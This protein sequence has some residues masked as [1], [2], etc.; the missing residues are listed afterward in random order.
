MEYT[1]FSQEETEGIGEKIAKKI[2][3][4]RIENQARVIS[5]EGELGSG[6]TTFLK[7]FARGFGIEE[8]IKSPSFVIMKKYRLPVT[9]Y[10]LPITYFYHIDCYRIEKSKEILA[11]GWQNIIFNPGNI[12]AIEWGDKIKDILPKDYIK[13][14]FSH[15]TKH[16]RKIKI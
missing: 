1:T 16:K 10:Q 9:R 8:I 15:L 13:I 11:L 4:G 3:K 7:G 2:L 14:S 12:V 6:K 5:L